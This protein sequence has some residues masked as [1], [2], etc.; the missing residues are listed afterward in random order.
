MLEMD[1]LSIQE[2][3]SLLRDKE[4]LLR[5]YLDTL[6]HRAVKEK[7]A[8][9]DDLRRLKSVIQQLQLDARSLSMLILALEKTMQAYW[10]SEQNAYSLLRLERRNLPDGTVEMND[11]SQIN[12]KMNKYRIKTSG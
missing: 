12:Q 5:N 10:R 3:C 2:L 4:Y 1:I 7:D 6:E 9:P 8:D 11:L